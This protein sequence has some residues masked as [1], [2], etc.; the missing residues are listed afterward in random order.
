M[1]NN[2][3]GEAIKQI[4]G[5]SIINKQ[6]ISA[7]E[8]EKYYIK[9]DIYQNA[10]EV[11][12]ILSPY[13]GSHA[14]SKPTNEASDLKYNTSKVTYNLMSP[15]NLNSYY[16]IINAKDI[17]WNNAYLKYAVKQGDCKEPI[18]YQRIDENTGQPYM[19]TYEQSAY[20]YIYTIPSYIQ[21]SYNLI[22][23]LDYIFNRT[24]MVNFLV[25]VVKE[26]RNTI[27]KYNTLHGGINEE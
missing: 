14:I 13:G 5:N 7:E 23:V 16:K 8:I 26:Q 2:W 10:I 3:Q 15:M 17:I 25:N 6:G 4:Y 22:H 12:D 18:R 27:N 21:T 20:E 11:P 24:K 1:I 9:S 19:T